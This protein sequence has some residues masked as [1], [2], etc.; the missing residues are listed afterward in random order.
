L[1]LANQDDPQNVLVYSIDATN[2]QLTRTQIV[3]VG[4]NPTF[5]RAIVLP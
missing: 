1:I 4:G 3:P 2:G 5:T